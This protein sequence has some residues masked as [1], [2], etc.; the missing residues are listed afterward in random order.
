MSHRAFDSYVGVPVAHSVYWYKDR[1]NKIFVKIT[2][3]IKIITND[4]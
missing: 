3:L 2:N 1:F 4:P